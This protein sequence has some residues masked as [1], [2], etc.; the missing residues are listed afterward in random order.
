MISMQAQRLR[1]RWAAALLIAAGLGASAPV[2]ATAAAH[3]DPA[4][5]DPASTDP[6]ALALASGAARGAV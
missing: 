4:S 2:V 1:N 6:Y 3:A 5:I